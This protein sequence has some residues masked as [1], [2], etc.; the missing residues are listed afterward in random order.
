MRSRKSGSS[1]FFLSRFLS[2]VLSISCPSAGSGGERAAWRGQEKGDSHRLPRRL[3]HLSESITHEKHSHG[4][5]ATRRIYFF[6]SIF[7]FLF[8]LVMG[9]ARRRRG[10]FLGGLSNDVEKQCVYK[11]ALCIHRVIWLSLAVSYAWQIFLR[12]FFRV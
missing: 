12:L 2:T 9:L 1:F 5:T 7:F 6:T 8:S 10:C 3:L 4:S 11:P